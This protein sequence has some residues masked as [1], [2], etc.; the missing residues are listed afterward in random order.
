MARQP[1]GR[2]TIGNHIAGMMQ[3]R[4]NLVTD[5]WVLIAQDRAA[6]PHDFAP[7]P[8]S[9][10]ATS[11]PFCRGHEAETP[12]A[13][14]TLPRCDANCANGGDARQRGRGGKARRSRESNAAQLAGVGAGG[15]GA[16]GV[17]TTSVEAG[18]VATVAMA[19]SA[20]DW[21]VRVV[22]NKYPALNP[23]DAGLVAAP[24]AGELA[25]G[26]GLHEVIVEAPHHATRFGE[27]TSLQARLTV[28]AWRDRLRELHADSR[29]GYGLVFKNHGA[30]GGASIEH[31]H[32]QLIATPWVPT[33]VQRELEQV[34]RFHEQS[35]R[36]L[37]CHLLD[38]ELAS[39]SRLVTQTDRF[40][41][42]CPYASR[43]PLETWLMPRR[44]EL[45]FE[46]LSDE[47]ADELASILHGVLDRMEQSPCVRGYNLWIHT[48]PFR[49]HRPDAFH[50]HLEIA[51]RV[52]NV[53]GF[54]WGGGDFINPVPPE[55]AAADLR[56]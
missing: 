50:W 6:R 54:E 15:V 21:Q 35:Q 38:E 49:E 43:F 46:D 34:A 37:F 40:V 55:D 36:C 45:R 1:L 39:G 8:A 48:A 25:M 26:A 16:G 13:V 19:E 12:S 56:M 51:P 47:G 18:G 33:A 14:L 20:S 17:E 44:H 9:R 10:L 4:R 7:E 41:A 53:A 52:T 30:A 3:L 22:P 5:S 29:L 27:L 11:C 24:R 32:S 31:V 23:L 42:Y 2:R 28:R